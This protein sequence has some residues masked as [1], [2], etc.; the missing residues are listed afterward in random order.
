MTTCISS[1]AQNLWMDRNLE[2][3]LA[4]QF[5]KKNLNKTWWK[6]VECKINQSLKVSTFYLEI[7]KTNK[8]GID[9]AP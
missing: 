1:E 7:E 6:Y 4:P 2:I 9:L 3:D 8:T 5:I